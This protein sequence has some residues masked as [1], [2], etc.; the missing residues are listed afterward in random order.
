MDT[1][2]TLELAPVLAAL[3][4]GLVAGSLLERWILWRCLS[5]VEWVYRRMLFL[6]DTD[7]AAR[8]DAPKFAA[9]ADTL[10]IGN[11]LLLILWLFRVYRRTIAMGLLGVIL[12]AGVAIWL[13]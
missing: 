1:M 8:K 6:G 3:I 11:P 4:V 7:P 5:S 9:I 10:R 12:T 2:D 13:T